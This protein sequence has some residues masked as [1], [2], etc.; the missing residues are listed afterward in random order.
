MAMSSNSLLSTLTCHLATRAHL[1]RTRPEEFVLKL[2]K[3]RRGTS[4]IEK[5][6]QI[7]GERVDRIKSGTALRCATEADLKANSLQETQH[8]L[9]KM[10]NTFFLAKSCLNI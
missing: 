5:A 4:R 8:L 3:S 9:R 1:K 10:A 7:A 6:A 2:V